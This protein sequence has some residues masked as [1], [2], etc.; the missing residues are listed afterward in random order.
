MLHYHRHDETIERLKIENRFITYKCRLLITFA[1]T[2]KND[3]NF[4]TNK[5]ILTLI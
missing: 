3:K 1:K 5:R 2:D 4:G